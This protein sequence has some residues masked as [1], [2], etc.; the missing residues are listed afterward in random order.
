MLLLDKHYKILSL[1]SLKTG[2]P[3]ITKWDV[4]L[5]P[6]HLSFETQISFSKRDVEGISLHEDN[7]MVINI[8]IWKRDVKRVLIDQSS[9]TYV[10]YWEDFQG[11]KLEMDL[12]RPFK[13]S[14]MDFSEKQVQVLG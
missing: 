4:S 12:L 6:K 1:K 13:G 8:Q 3:K 10:M 14:L 11:L 2:N 9:S 5:R 7:L